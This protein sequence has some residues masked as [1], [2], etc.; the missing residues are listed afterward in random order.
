MHVWC[1]KMHCG[2]ALQRCEWQPMDCTV[3]VKSMAVQHNA[4][5]CMMQWGALAKELSIIGQFGVCWR[6]IHN[7]QTAL[8]QHD[9]INVMLKLQLYFYARLGFQHRKLQVDSLK[10]CP[11]ATI[12]SIM[13]NNSMIYG[14]SLENDRISQ[15]DYYSNI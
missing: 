3:A 14:N 7:E 2:I 8:M 13:Q 6:P 1:I 4:Q 5:T 12:T 15:K 11:S 10:Q 9:C